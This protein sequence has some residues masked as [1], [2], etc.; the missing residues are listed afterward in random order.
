MENNVPRF[1]QVETVNGY[2]VIDTQLPNLM[3]YAP[4]TADVCTKARMVHVTML[5]NK[6]PESDD[7]K[8]YEEY[9]V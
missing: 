1:K 5:L 9:R 6:N 4:A 7:L 8:Q 3:Y 2:G